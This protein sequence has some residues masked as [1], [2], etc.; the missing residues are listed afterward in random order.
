MRTF[1]FLRQVQELT[2]V[3]VAQRAGLSQTVVSKAERGLLPNTPA[4]IDA[5]KRLACVLGVFP[6][7]ETLDPKS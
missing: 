1:R 3:E 5:K 2:Q 7:D 6:P 4:G